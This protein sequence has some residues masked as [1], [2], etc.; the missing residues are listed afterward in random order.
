MSYS[1]FSINSTADE[2]VKING[3]T[4]EVS[5]VGSLGFDAMDIDLTSF[6]GR[7]FGLNS[8]F[9][10]SVDLVEINPSSGNILWSTPVM[11][12]NI[13]LASAEGL[14]NINTQLKIGLDDDADTT[15]D[16]LTDLA[17]NGSTSNAT[18]FAADFDGLGVDRNNQMFSVDTEPDSGITKLYRIDLEN[19]T[20]S[21]IASFSF[22]KV[23]A[24]DI[25]IWGQ[26]AFVID[27]AHNALFQV[28]LVDGSLENALNLEA[29][30]LGLAPVP[31]PSA[32][33]LLGT[34]LVG[35]AALRRYRE[36]QVTV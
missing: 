12:N 7:L 13:P 16:F 4:G 32:I 22:S 18:L 28:S 31:I 29:S 24:N 20:I 17:L 26:S 2:L 21:E 33:I 35:L 10:V 5:V 11:R 1:F 14:T 30:Y 15:S 34:G 9:G 27:H 25:V 23:A 36:K 6:G 8:N 3:A 19:V